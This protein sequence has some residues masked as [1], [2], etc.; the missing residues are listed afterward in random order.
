M[1]VRTNLG[2][3]GDTDVEH[4]PFKGHMFKVAEQ[5]LGKVETHLFSVTGLDPSI[6]RTRLL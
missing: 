1:L 6:L 2:L 5:T 4:D 3:V